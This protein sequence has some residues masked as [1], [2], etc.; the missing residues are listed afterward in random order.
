MLRSGIQV[1]HVELDYQAQSWSKSR[2][3]VAKI[4]WHFGEFFPRYSFV[5]T[6]PRLPAAKMVKV[7]N[8]RGNISHIA[9][10]RPWCEPFVSMVE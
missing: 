7:H 4:E 5:V 9:H 3:V 1:K 2:R 6:N 10:I 8:G